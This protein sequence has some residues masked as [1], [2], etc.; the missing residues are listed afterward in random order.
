[1]DP[2]H[3]ITFAKWAQ[4]I[5][6]P[7]SV[8]TLN[9]RNVVEELVHAKQVRDS[10][11]PG[12]T[13]TPKQA[14]PAES[15]CSPCT[16]LNN[17]SHFPASTQRTTPLSLATTETTRLRVTTNHKS[18]PLND[19]EAFW[20]GHLS[21]S[22]PGPRSPQT[23]QWMYRRLSRSRQLEYLVSLK[24]MTFREHIGAPYIFRNIQLWNIDYEEC[25]RRRQFFQKNGEEEFLAEY[26]N[27]DYT[28]AVDFLHIDPE[29]V[30]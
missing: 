26:I 4:Q 21:K 7:P 22:S 16:T 27:S 30:Y 5:Y 1:M 19:T 15:F 14:H 13:F 23:S 20:Q 6:G 2:A 25:H 10:S 12:L 29:E 8:P 18:V 11:T 24:I 17:E 9:A 3:N 28:G